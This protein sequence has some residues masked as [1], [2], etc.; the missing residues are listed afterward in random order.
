MT[1]SGEY[2]AVLL[3]VVGVEFAAHWKVCAR[4]REPEREAEKPEAKVLWNGA[5]GLLRDGAFSHC[6]RAVTLEEKD[7]VREEAWP[8][9]VD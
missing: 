1:R 7:V 2:F 8:V 4:G 9:L 5:E 6:G 3:Q